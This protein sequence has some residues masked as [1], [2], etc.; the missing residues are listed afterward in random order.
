MR[1]PRKT[2]RH[3]ILTA[4]SS[5]EPQRLGATDLRFGRSVLNYHKFRYLTA[6]PYLSF[7]LLQPLFKLIQFLM[8]LVR[9]PISKLFK[10]FSDQRHFIHPAVNI[11]P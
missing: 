6:K 9:Q 8:Q 3:H 7:C 4:L 10:M 11:Y 1:C 5:L 2:P